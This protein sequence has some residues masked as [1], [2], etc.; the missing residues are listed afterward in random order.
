MRFLIIDGNIFV[1]RRHIK[2]LTY[3]FKYILIEKMEDFEFYLFEVDVKLDSFW[4]NQDL[5]SSAILEY[6]IKNEV[7]IL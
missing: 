6:G 3:F 4:E 1:L 5:L 7:W 2:L